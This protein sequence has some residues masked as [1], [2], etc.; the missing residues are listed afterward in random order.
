MTNFNGEAQP[1]YVTFKY[2]K[3][4]DENAKVRV[5]IY[6]LSTAKTLFAITDATIEYI[7]RIQWTKNPIHLCILTLNRHQNH[8]KRFLSYF[9]KIYTCRL[10]DFI[11]C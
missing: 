11:V 3:V 6:S 4:G 2:P 10:N 9:T 8:L 5:G 7:P 1:E